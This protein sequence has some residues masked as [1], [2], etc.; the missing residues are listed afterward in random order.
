MGNASLSSALI[1]SIQTVVNPFHQHLSTELKNFYCNCLNILP[2]LFKHPLLINE[3][4]QNKGIESLLLIINRCE[5][6]LRAVVLRTLVVL[7]WVC[8]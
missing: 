5:D 8:F 2:K 6:N 4:R 7:S 1:V 3:F